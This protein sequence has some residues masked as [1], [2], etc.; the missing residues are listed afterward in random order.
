MSKRPVETPANDAQ[1]HVD[2]PSRPSAP[3]D[4]NIGR[5]DDIDSKGDES[6]RQE[7][8]GRATGTGEDLL[9]LFANG[10]DEHLRDG[11]RAGNG[12]D[13]EGDVERTDEFPQID[14]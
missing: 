2:G 12:D 3:T 1:L 11:F 4:L 14:R 10:S 6:R 13:P 5:T 9:S 8:T 7:L